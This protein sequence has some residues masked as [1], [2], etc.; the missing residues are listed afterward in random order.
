ME[1]LWVLPTSM[2]QGIGR[3]LLEHAA[4]HARS[5]GCTHISIESDPNA[6]QFYQHCGAELVAHTESIVDGVVRRLPILELR[7][8]HFAGRVDGADGYGRHGAC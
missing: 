7:T 1:H 2:G 3:A 5:L 4:A 6:C 8:S